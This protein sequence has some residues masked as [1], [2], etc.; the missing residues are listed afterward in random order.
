MNFRTTVDSGLQKEKDLQSM[1]KKTNVVKKGKGTVGT[2]GKH[3]RD[4]LDSHE[5]M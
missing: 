1:T 4:D 3:K 2:G 5:S